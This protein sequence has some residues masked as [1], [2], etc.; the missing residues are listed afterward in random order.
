MNIALCTG[1]CPI[2][3]LCLR[4]MQQTS[5]NTRTNIE[6][7]CIPNNYIEFRPYEENIQRSHRYLNV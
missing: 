6:D 3:D 4:Y 1:N 7:I 5:E 2:S